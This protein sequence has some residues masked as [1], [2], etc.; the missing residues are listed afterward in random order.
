M[1][2]LILPPDYKNE[3]Q[4]DGAQNHKKQNNDNEIND[5]GIQKNQKRKDQKDEKKDPFFIPVYS[6]IINTV[7]ELNKIPREQLLTIFSKTEIDALIK[8]AGNEKY[9]RQYYHRAKKK[10]QKFEEIFGIKIN[11]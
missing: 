3:T 1:V 4:V 11:I 10:Y 5:G 8:R 9:I 7:E 6:D 2:D